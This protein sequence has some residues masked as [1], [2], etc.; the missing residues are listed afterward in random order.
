MGANEVPCVKRF[1]SFGI[2]GD[3]PPATTA[4]RANRR[5]T[6]ATRTLIPTGKLETNDHLGS[7]ARED[8]VELGELFPYKALRTP[9]LAGR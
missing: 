1:R 7:R 5:G 3:R 2:C 6:F 9:Y 4:L 8:I